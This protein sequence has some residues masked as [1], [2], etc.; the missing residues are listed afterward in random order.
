MKKGLRLFQRFSILKM[1]ILWVA[2]SF[3]YHCAGV[4]PEQRPEQK[5][6]PPVEEKIEQPKK[7]ETPGSRPAPELPPKP[8]PPSVSPSVSKPSKVTSPSQPLPSS[9]PSLRTTKVVWNSVNL[10][11]G[12]GPN[13]RVI[14]NA[15]KGISL[16]ILE[17]KGNW[18]RV[19]LEDGSEA[20]VIKAA[21]S[22][23]PK[24][25]PATTPKPKPM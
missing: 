15:K 1:V 20:W 11:E 18:L 9:P 22:D 19:R 10:R 4:K 12:P 8:A 3:A 24:P 21:T 23:A 2:L 6:A 13:Y 5:S 16:S 25:P 17:D 14:G 7:E